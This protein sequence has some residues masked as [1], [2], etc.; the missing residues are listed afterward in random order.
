MELSAACDTVD[1]GATGVCVVCLVGR[2][3]GCIQFGILEQRHL[4]SLAVTI[5]HC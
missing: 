5:P 4:I 3:C 1:K 2:H